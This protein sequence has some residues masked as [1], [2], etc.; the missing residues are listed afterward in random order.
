MRKNKG[1]RV[2]VMPHLG[3]KLSRLIVAAEQLTVCIALPL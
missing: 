2:A 1:L 3:F